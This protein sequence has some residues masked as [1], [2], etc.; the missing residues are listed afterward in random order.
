MTKSIFVV[1]KNRSGTKWLSNILLN[2]EKITGVQ[3]QFHAGILESNILNDISLSFGTLND[4]DNYIGFTEWFSATDYFEI[5][6]I[7]KSFLYKKHYLCYYDLFN[8][9]MNEFCRKENIESWLQK[10][11][12]LKLPEIYT[13]FKSSKFIIIERELIGNIGSAW[14]LQLQN[15]GKSSLFRETYLYALTKKIHKKLRKNNNVFFLKYSDLMEQ[16]EE[17]LKKLCRFLDVSYSTDLQVVKFERNT[18]YKKG[19]K[20]LGTKKIILIKIY[21]FL[22]MNIPYFVLRWVYS[23]ITMIKRTQRNNR[24]YTIPGTFSGSY[25]KLKKK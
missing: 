19:E 15:S 7:K 24:F 1:G 6:G 5:T 9:L 3:G 4:I 12:S 20:K 13:F 8:E 18:S 25:K 14:F 11:N 21:Y 10:I 17:I 2:H 23:L 22:L 16:P